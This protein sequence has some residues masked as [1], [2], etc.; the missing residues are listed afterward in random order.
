MQQEKEADGGQEVQRALFVD[1]EQPIL[2]ALRRSLTVEGI[3]VTVTTDPHEALELVRTQHFHVVGADYR[4]PQMD[5][6][7]LLSEVQKASPHSYRLLI[8]AVHDFETAVDAVNR[9]G[10]F[11]FIQKPWDHRELVAV[12][13]EAFTQYRLR[14]ENERLHKLVQA[15]NAEL[16]ELNRSLE[17][18]VVER[19]SALLD[20]MIAALDFRDTETQWHS[21]RVA[22]YTRR[23]AEALGVTDEQALWNI[24]Q[25]ALLHDIGKIG[26][27]DTILLKPGKLTPDEWEVM[28]THPEL[29][30]RL[31]R[32]MSFLEE[33]R[34]IV[35]QHQERW[36]GRGYPLGLSGEQI[37]VGALCFH[38]ADTLDAITSDRPYRKGQ[39][40]DMARAEVMRCR[41][42]QF[43]PHVVDAF[44]TLP[45]SEFEAIRRRT[46]EEADVEAAAETADLP[47]ALREKA[48]RRGTG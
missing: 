26:I 18:L 33:S 10:I 13:R 19:T 25:G 11:R 12:L 20:G 44:M 27:S 5:G 41:G 46:L 43:A 24:E 4:M 39:P 32:K 3:D 31:L 14:E 2:N 22:L 38:I 34:L 17:R 42:T 48:A 21:R 37:H 23:I 30:Y 8:S 9:G 36:D 47:E 40:F 15:R 7:R 16:E 35:L 28:K 6:V 1:D 45:D 29:G